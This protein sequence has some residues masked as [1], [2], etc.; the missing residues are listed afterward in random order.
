M[1]EYQITYRSCEGSHGF[2]FIMASNLEEA[3][4]DAGV[5][6]DGLVWPVS[7]LRIEIS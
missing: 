7:I 3:R 6:A 4:R 2:H 5:W 1:R